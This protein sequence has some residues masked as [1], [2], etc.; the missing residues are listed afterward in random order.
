MMLFGSCQSIEQN[1]EQGEE[2]SLAILTEQHDS[3]ILTDVP[4]AIAQNYFVLNDA[5]KPASPKITTK[6]EFDR[7]FGN[8]T[9][10]G[11]QGQPTPIDFEQQ[12]VIAIVLDRSDFA[13]TIEP[14]DLSKHAANELHIRYA[15]VVG[16]RQE[17][18]TQP[19]LILVVDKKYEAAVVLDRAD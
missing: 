15:V 9:L 6:A 2:D 5:P 12:F 14:M 4:F 18:I 10:M 3:T 7:I 16:E 11:E 8:A 17:Y 19:A 1:R 13:T